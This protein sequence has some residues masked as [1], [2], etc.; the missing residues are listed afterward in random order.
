MRVMTFSRLLGQVR[1]LAGHRGGA[2][3]QQHAHAAHGDARHGQLEDGSVEVGPVLASLRLG[4]G[5]AKVGATGFA[6]V[7]WNGLTVVLGFPVSAL[8][9]E[10]GPRVIVM[11]TRGVRTYPYPFHLNH[12]LNLHR[13]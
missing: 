8:P 7:A 13:R 4:L 1:D 2:T 12:P 11:K 3:P 6:L 10:A 9:V 5:G